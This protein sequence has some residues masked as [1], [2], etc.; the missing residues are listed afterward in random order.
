[1]VDASSYGTQQQ[2]GGAPTGQGSTYNATLKGKINGLEET[3]KA[4][5][6]EI[7]F[8]HNEIGCLKQ[9][10]GELEESLAQKTTEIRNVLTSDVQK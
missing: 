1:M 5:T 2:M 7:H 4:L 8:Y 9:E 6:E 10:K 3:C